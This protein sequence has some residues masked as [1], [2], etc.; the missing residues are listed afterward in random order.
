MVRAAR[1]ES[2]ITYVDFNTGHYGGDTYLDILEPFIRRIK[3]E[4]GVLVG[5]QT[6]P[7]HDLRRYDALRAMGL[8]RVSFCFELFD[9]A[10]FRE[11]CPGKD[12]EY[13]LKRYL[14]AHAIP[15]GMTRS[16]LIFTLAL[17]VS[18]GAAVI[19]ERL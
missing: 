4:V 3:R 13:G 12:R 7:H 16:V 11:V 18:Y 19:V 2:G 8:N 9:E 5:I 1:R 17:A 15:K 10:I 14:D 6:P